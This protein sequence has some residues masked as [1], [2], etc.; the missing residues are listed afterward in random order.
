MGTAFIWRR[1]LEMLVPAK[2]LK[3]RDFSGRKL[4]KTSNSPALVARGK[5][6]ACKAGDTGSI[7][8]SGRTPRR[9]KWLPT[10]VFF[11]GNSMDRGAWW[12]IVHGV[13]KE[14][15]TTR[16]LNENNSLATLCF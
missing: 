12:A 6:S 7:P 5:E 16:Q 3:H 11:S 4:G 1:M 10:P 9:R 13:T 15:D 2:M 14:S 8:G